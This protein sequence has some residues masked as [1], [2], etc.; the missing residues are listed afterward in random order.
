MGRYIDITLCRHVDA[1]PTTTNVTT[2]KRIDYDESTKELASSGDG[3]K[4]DTFLA[5]GMGGVSG[6]ITLED[7]VQAAALLA[8]LEGTFTFK[9]TQGNNLAVT[10]LVTITNVQFFEDS[11]SQVHDDIAGNTVSF[12][13]TA[14]TIVQST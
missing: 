2:V 5:K 7:P 13:G 9:G 3:D 11:G 14:A 4:Q 8:L 1:T 10:D 6:R 12:L